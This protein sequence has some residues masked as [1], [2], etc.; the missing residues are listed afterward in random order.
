VLKAEIDKEGNIQDLS[1]LSGD[2]ELA[3]AALKAVK[4]WKYRPYFL[5]G[6]PVSVETQ[7]TVIFALQTQ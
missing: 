2:P 1:V 5:Q 6:Q 7:I 3:P 4:Q